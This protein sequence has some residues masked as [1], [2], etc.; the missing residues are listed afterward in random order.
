VIQYEYQLKL[1]TAELPQSLRERLADDRVRSFGLIKAG[2]PA[3]YCCN[4][5]VEASMICS[6]YQY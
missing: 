1:L 2:F 4:E 6:P 5:I 3:S